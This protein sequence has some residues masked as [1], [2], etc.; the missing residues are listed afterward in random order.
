MYTT[1]I[2]LF[3]ISFVL[4]LLRFIYNL[5]SLKSL[6]NIWRP[7]LWISF[8]YI[9]LS[10]IAQNLVLLLL[11]SPISKSWHPTTAGVCLDSTKTFYV[12]GGTLC[13][14]LYLKPVLTSLGVANTIFCDVLTLAIAIPLILRMALTKTDRITIAGLYSL[15]VFT[16]ACGAVRMWQIKKISVNGDSSGLVEWGVV[17][18]NVGVRQLLLL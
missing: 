7:W 17:E 16:A 3:K 14:D 12:M 15:G 10:H 1:G 11:C 13:P 2:S 5:P 9:T 18:I 6:L 8:W 4:A